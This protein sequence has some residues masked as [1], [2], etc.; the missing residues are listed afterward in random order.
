MAI[1]S[2]DTYLQRAIQENLTDL[3]KNPYIINETI[4]KDFDPDIREAFLDQYKITESGQRKKEIPVQFT[5]PNTNDYQLMVLIQ[6]K[7]AQ[8]AND[9]EQL[10]T[11]IGTD[12]LAADDFSIASE[13]PLT[14]D[15]LTHR[16]YLTLPREALSVSKV[17]GMSIRTRIDP[18]DPHIVHIPYM[19]ALP[20]G[21]KFTVYYVPYTTDQRTGQLT[22]S[23]PSLAYG[24]TLNETFDIDMIARNMNDLRCLEALMRIIFIYLRLDAQEQIQYQLANLEF[25]GTDL[26]DPIN[27]EDTSA[28]GYQVYYRRIEITYTTTYSAKIDAFS[29]LKQIVHQPYDSNFGKEK[30]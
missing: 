19:P 18:K 20:S 22:K 27:R 14:V 3:L 23:K 15:T 7:G 13:V 6:F 24:Y 8:E 17:A 30:S 16:A 10:G 21:K 11:L 28:A 26:L 4:L 29:E 2:I 1:S 25:Q 9:K 12:D 5:Y